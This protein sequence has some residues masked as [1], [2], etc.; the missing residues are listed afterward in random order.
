MTRVTLYLYRMPAPR[1]HLPGIRSPNCLYQDPNTF[2]SRIGYLQGVLY[3]VD[4]NN[5]CKISH[6]NFIEFRTKWLAIKETL[7]P[8]MII[9]RDDNDWI[10]CKGFNSKE[11]ME[12]FII[13]YQP[14]V[15][16]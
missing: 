11:E 1:G 3:G 10:D 16:H 5:S 9:Y 8:F 4:P 2:D 15:K 13:N 12:L 6:D 7:P 14:D